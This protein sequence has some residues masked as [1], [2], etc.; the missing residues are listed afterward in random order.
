[1]TRELDRA[2]VLPT[3]AVGERRGT[4]LEAEVDA[5][6]I[7]LVEAEVTVTARPYAT[8][9]L[10]LRKAGRAAPKG[11][12]LWHSFHYLDDYTEPLVARAAGC[13]RWV[14]TKKN[15]SWGGRA[16]RLR[17]RLAHGI[18][19]Q[20]PTMVE[21]FFPDHRGPVR[22]IP[23]GVDGERFAP[24]PDRP[25]RPR[26]GLA[27]GDVLVAHV[28]HLLP[29]KNQRH[30]VEALARTPPRIHLAL[31]GRPLDPDYAAEVEA[32]ATELGVAD[33]THLL[34]PVEDVPGLLRSA[35]VFAFAST[36]EA[37]PVAVL[38][39][40]AT[41]LPVVVSDIPG[42]RHLVTDGRNGLRFPVGGVAVLAAGLAHLA[43][44]PGR[45]RA[46]GEAARATVTSS[47][48]LADEAEA[49]QDLYDRVLSR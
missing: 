32:T 42:T 35:D 25:F 12:D 36:D 30:L 24:G 34:G 29:N 9:P 26:L 16:W 45:R 39:A 40:M 18:A 41:G 20:N 3:I 14:F 37:C 22:T 31:A 46:L 5:A 33:R 43:D 7:E 28:A 1:M 2:R 19:A 8:L 4:P 48:T 13:R 38:E 44:D 47:R 21:D 6:G 23:P 27:E 10:R 17:A 11:H 49:Y 15:M